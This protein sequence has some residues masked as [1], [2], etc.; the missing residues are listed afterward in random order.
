MNLRVR[1]PVIDLEEV[2]RGVE[3]AAQS[4]QP[5]IDITALLRIM[6]ARKGVILATVGA[7][8][9]LTLVAWLF[10]TPTYSA[11]AVLMLD[12]RKNAIADVNAV[13]SGLPT[14]SAASVQNE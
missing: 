10:I 4:D 9:A 8:L 13:L 7:V 1:H 3:Y 5:G 6:R 14:D 12:Q 11:T 2:E